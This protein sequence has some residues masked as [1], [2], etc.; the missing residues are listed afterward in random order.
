LQR[1]ARNPWKA[2][3]KIRRS[4]AHRKELLER[5]GNPRRI[6]RAKRFKP[7]RRAAF[8]N[9]H[10]RVLIARLGDEKFKDFRGYKWHVPRDDQDVVPSGKRGVN[11]GEATSTRNTVP[12]YRDTRKP[13][14]GVPAIRN[15]C[16]V[17]RHSSER[18]GDAIDDSLA[19]NLLKPL[20]LSA[21][22]AA[23]P[24]SQNNTQDRTTQIRSPRRSAA[25]S[26]S[27]VSSR[28]TRGDSIPATSRSLMYLAHEWQTSSS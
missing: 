18:L 7:V 15:Q 12:Q 17:R 26:S 1:Q 9:H 22:P 3:E 21:K 20:G 8:W 6:E 13:A 19:G 25:E 5:T 24:A 27:A 16:Q 2:C 4:A 14:V 23:L 11:S 10:V 28:S